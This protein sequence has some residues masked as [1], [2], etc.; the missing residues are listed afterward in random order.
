MTRII[1][2][3]GL[4]AENAHAF[5]RCIYIHGT[6]EERAIGRPASYGCIRMKSKDVAALYDKIVLG[7][8]VQIVPDHLPAP[9]T[10]VASSPTP[11]I[12]PMPNDQL[13]LA[14]D[15]EKP[16][17]RRTLIASRRGA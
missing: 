10:A 16:H 12:P 4:E 3:R 5:G 7:T 17:T 9:K 8:V 11:P 15:N 13:I 1:W 14:R 2:L 6:P